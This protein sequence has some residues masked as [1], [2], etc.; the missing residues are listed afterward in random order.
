MTRIIIS[1]EIWVPRKPFLCPASALAP[2]I[3]TNLFKAEWEIPAA[4]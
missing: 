4:L 2:V 1:E 3:R